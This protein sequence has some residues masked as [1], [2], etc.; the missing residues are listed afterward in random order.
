MALLGRR[1]RPGEGTRE[2]HWHRSAYLRRLPAW[3]VG[4]FLG[5]CVRVVVVSPHPDDEVLGCG[6]LLHAC[7]ARGMPIAIASVTGGEACYPGNP[8]WPRAHLLRERRRELACALAAL[9][10]PTQA[11]P[12]G[13]ADGRVARDEAS[14]LRRL[15]AFIGP[16]DLVLGPWHRDGHPDHE[17]VAR[18]A[19]RA[20]LAAGAR[21]RE[22]PV[23]G[24]H[25]AR[26]TGEDFDAA[27]AVRIA[28]SPEARAAK[29]DA[30]ACFRSQTGVGVDGIDAPILTPDVVARFARPFEVFFA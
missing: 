11:V 14:L 7:A 23:W 5:R 18:A 2:A 6:G 3:T 17:A 9:G 13:F 24:W 1:I 16:G 30:M 28:L 15:R 25:W 27:D 10:V 20:A 26:P 8:R 22:F 12:L 4:A 29:R 19:R 21:H